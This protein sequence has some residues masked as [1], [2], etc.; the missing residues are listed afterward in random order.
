[1]LTPIEP[2]APSMVSF[3]AH[4]IQ[5]Q[6]RQR[7]GRGQGID[8]IEHAAMPRQQVAAVLDAGLPL[9]QRLEQVAHDADRRQQQ[10]QQHITGAASGSFPASGEKLSTTPP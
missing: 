8:A 2:V 5:D 10:Q 1:V 9:Q 6:R 7:Q 3:M 4:E